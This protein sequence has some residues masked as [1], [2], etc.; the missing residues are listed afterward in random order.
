MNSV[1]RMQ[2]FDGIFQKKYSYLKKTKTPFSGK[3]K[4][5]LLNRKLICQ[6]SGALW[7]T[8]ILSKV[9]RKDK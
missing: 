2:S 7:C 1:F 3:S 9:V 6:T 5:N 8:I 4:L